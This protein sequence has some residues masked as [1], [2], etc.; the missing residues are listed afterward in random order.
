VLEPQ[1]TLFFILLVLA[2]AG[3]VTWLAMTRLVAVRV[4]AALLAFL[5][6]AIFGIAVVNRYYDYYQTWGA[7]FSDLGGSAGQSVPQLA[8]ASPL[9]GQAVGKQIAASADLTVAAQ[10][11]FLFTTTVTGPDSHLTRQVE[12]YLP[13]E[14][15]QPAYKNARFP[16][17]ELLHGSPGM[18]SSW[19]N[20]MN[21][22]PIYLAGL[23][24]GHATPAVLVLPDTDGGQWY[25]EQC[26]N[27]PNGP[28][29]MTFVGREVPDWVSSSLRVMPPGPAWGIGGYSEGGYCAVNIGLQYASRFG[30][31]GSLS[32][33]FAPIGSV[34]PA[35]GKNRVVDPRPFQKYPKLAR[36]N[37]PLDYIQQAPASVTIPYLW[38]AAG[39]SDIADLRAA[40][41][42]REYALLRVPE[43]PILAVA[44][45]HHTA[46]VW[47]AALGPMLD[48]MTPKLTYQAG[49]LQ[50][51]ARVKPPPRKG[52]HGKVRATV[53]GSGKQVAANQLSASP[54]PTHA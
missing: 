15:F 14:Y 29:D 10:S 8:S 40:E 2:F 32:G 26:L 43:V 51:D 41:L 17:V 54:K 23:R 7:L 53:T 12:V 11:G 1:G 33:Y 47:R 49:Q 19:I 35:G 9:S 48:W 37:T 39:G 44:G 27:F 45:G 5:P 31:V 46:T 30:Y 18:P 16:A 42:F 28:Q 34:L 20:V 24:S 36:L 52:T 25:S 4:I 6:A 38:L 22:I 50:T 13:P 3:L 21:L